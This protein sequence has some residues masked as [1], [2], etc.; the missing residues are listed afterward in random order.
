MAKNKDDEESYC[1]GGGYWDMVED[2]EEEICF[3]AQEVIPNLY[4]GSISAATCTTSLKE[5]KITHI[6][7]ISTNP[8]KIKE[9]T[10]LCINIEDESQKD[11]SS[12][13]QQC[14][15]FIENGRKLGGILVHCSAGVSRSAS[16]VIS[17]LMS[18]FF[19]PFWYCMQYLRNIRPCI[20][21]NTGFINQLINYEATILK[22]QN[23]ISTTTTTTTTTTITKK[24]L[25][26]N[27]CNNDDN[28]SGGSGGG[29]E[30]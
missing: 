4:I 29:M 26:S 23:V 21:P 18:V 8:P 16:V 20:Q 24:K 28:S 19:K 13:F 22:N 30:S 6:L 10:T 17:Y 12:Y 14:H 11:I 15:G 2:L 5:H 9:F 1:G 7:S 27:D 25:I 3:D